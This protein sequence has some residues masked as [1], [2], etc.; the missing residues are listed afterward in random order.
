MSKAMIDGVEFPVNPESVRWDYSVKLA[1]HPTIGGKVIQ[2]Y[3]WSMGDLMIGGSFGNVARQA[4][5][6]EHLKD[7]ADKQAPK[8]DRLV[9]QPVRFTWAARNWDFWVYLRAVTQQGASVSIEANESVVAPKYQMRLFVAEDNG[10]IVKAASGAAQVAYINRLTA[11]L[12]WTKSSWNGPLDMDDL[13]SQ[14]QGLTPLDFIL[15]EYGRAQVSQVVDPAET[16]P[17]VSD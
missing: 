5:F 16:A 3:G 14:M 8:L 12:G 13:A 6:F 11:G 1:T 2:L 9:P 4:T 17:E 15:S 10:E 7:V